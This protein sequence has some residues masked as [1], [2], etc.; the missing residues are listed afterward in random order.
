MA[1]PSQHAK[2]R[3]AGY[4]ARCAI[5]THTERGRLSGRMAGVRALGSSM[6]SGLLSLVWLSS[7]VGTDS[8]WSVEQVSFNPGGTLRLAMRD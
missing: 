8:H 1:S 4:P 5:F 7:R 3:K 2:N 6:V